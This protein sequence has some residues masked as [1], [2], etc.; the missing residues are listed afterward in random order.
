MLL[1]GCAKSATYTEVSPD[2]SYVRIVKFSLSKSPG[3][4]KAP[5]PE[6]L[7]SPKNAAWKPS[8]VVKND[9]KTVTLTR[10]GKVGD[11]TI[12]DVL[13]KEKGVT[14]FKNFIK[15]TDLGDGKFQYTEKFVW[16]GKKDEGAENNTR[17]FGETLKS[18]APNGLITDADAKELSDLIQVKLARMMFGPDDQLIGG[19][20]LNPEGC[21]M[22][23]KA[24]VAELLNDQLALKYGDKMTEEQRFTF[25]RSLYD[26]MDD[27]GNL[28]D[29]TEKSKS[30]PPESDAG[31]VG[32]T[33]SVKLPGKI[34][35]HNGTYDRFSG[36]IFWTMT[37]LVTQTKPI[38]FT[39]ICD[40]SK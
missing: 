25:I 38:E 24:E 18:S 17:L 31:M 30:A 4:E 29:K 1:V 22:K 3:D 35:S 32:L 16:V 23:I 26:K 7:V 34:I 19:L 11:E 15:M 21:M 10:N 5:W 2:G 13:G 28:K 33:T 27:I 40:T 14:Q 36:K 37:S 39:A 20:L 9:E 8:E 6:T 12:T